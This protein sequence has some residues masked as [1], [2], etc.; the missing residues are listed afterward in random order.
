MTYDWY[1]IFNLT[2]FLATGLVARSLVLEL[3]G[4]GST[5]FEIFRGNEV[6]VQFD[7]AFLPV[8]FLEQNPYVQGTYAVYLDATD[9]VWFGFEVEA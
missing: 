7:D 2:E 8:S 3:D 4:R 6:G 5:T 9:N 1:K